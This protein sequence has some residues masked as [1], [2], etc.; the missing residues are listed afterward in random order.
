MGTENSRSNEFISCDDYWSI[1]ID[2]EFAIAATKLIHYRTVSSRFV[3]Y[4]D[5]SFLT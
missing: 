5:S 4:A 3:L 1:M 2:V